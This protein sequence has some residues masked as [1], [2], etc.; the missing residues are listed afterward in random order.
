MDAVASL[1]LAFHRISV[2]ENTTFGT[3]CHS[4]ANSPVLVSHGSMSS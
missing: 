2:V 4:S 1:A 3:A